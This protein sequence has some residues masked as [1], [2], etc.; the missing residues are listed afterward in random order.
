MA[1]SVGRGSIFYWISLKMLIVTVNPVLLRSQWLQHYY[2]HKIIWNTWCY[3]KSD[4]SAYEIS[5]YLTNPV[6]SELSHYSDQILYW[7]FIK[8]CCLNFQKDSIMIRDSCFY[9]F[10]PNVYEKPHLYIL[11]RNYKSNHSS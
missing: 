5:S 10:G 7:Y 4:S 3:R 2:N 11:H 8:R 6:A 9:G 1:K